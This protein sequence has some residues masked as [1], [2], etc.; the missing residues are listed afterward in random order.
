VTA[1][2]TARIAEE[3]ARIAAAL[4]AAV[5]PEARA[6]A[7]TAL[8]SRGLPASRDEN[9]RYAN[10][11]PVERARFAPSS[12]T[13]AAAS[14][15]AATLPASI[16]GAHRIVFVDGVLQGA[17][18]ETA[19]VAGLAIE[20][21]RAA[22]SA[23]R[24]GPSALAPAD[25]GFAL[26]NDAFAVDGVR[27]HASGRVGQL[28]EL[29]F[30]ATTDASES[31]S[32][33]RLEIDVAPGAS[34]RIVE[35][36]VGAADRASLVVSRASLRVGQSA[37]LR[38]YRVQQ[39]SPQATW[40]DSVD[41]SLDADADCQLFL[42]TTGAQS[43]RSTLEV[44]LAGRGARIGMHAAAVAA[45]RQVH[46]VYAVVDHRARATVTEQSFR[47]V[48]ADRARVAF[49]GKIV[50]RDNAAGTDSR[51]SLRGLLAGPEAEIDVR[52]QLEIYTDDVKCSHGATA[53]KLDDAMLFYLLSRG[54]D[55]D[56]ARALLE[57]AFLEDV[58]ARIDVPD[59]RRQVELALA[60]RMRGLAALGD[61]L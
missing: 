44:Q 60:G 22:G 39:C 40:I 5:A 3:H 20:S 1:S 30:V 36:H 35:R 50:V 13:P 32:Y 38:H 52:P 51:Q 7:L 27:L 33:P 15:L 16:E 45:G 14:A 4:P 9:W 48:A 25:L 11:R 8:A 26:L 17:L 10:L 31:A 29:V 41:A 53:G 23:A 47:G 12:G 46:D 61:F 55:R 56:T 57:W 21:L 19:T 58:V 49:N 37:E 2:T 6:A 54:L 43:S 24:P 18:P 34:L 59:L 42:L 28:V